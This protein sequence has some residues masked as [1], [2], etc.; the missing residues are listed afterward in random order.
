[1]KRS[2]NEA[3]LY[4]FIEKPFDNE[5]LVLTLQTARHAYRQGRELALRNAELL[6]LNR[7]LEAK[8]AERTAQLETANRELQRLSSTDALTDLANRRQLDE[9]LDEV[10]ALCWPRQPLRRRPGRWT[11]TTSSA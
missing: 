9:A 7:E 2:I 5:N 3:A 6:R 8:V 11:S 10:A 1:M 4:R